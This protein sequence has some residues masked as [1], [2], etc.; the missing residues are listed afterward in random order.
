[1]GKITFNIFCIYK[2]KRNKNGSSQ[3][4]TVAT[5][6]NKFSMLTREMK[7]SYIDRNKYP[8]YCLYIVPPVFITM[9]KAG[10]NKFFM[11]Y[12][13]SLRKIVVIQFR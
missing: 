2:H 11:R 12:P 9:G 3:Y 6:E 13:R 8:L 7:T 5:R 10:V 1:M 4:K